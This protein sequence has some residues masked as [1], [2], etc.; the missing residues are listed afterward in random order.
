MIENSLGRSPTPDQLEGVADQTG[1]PA[2]FLV[3]HPAFK[4]YEIVYPRDLDLV[5][6]IYS[7]T[8]LD[9][10]GIGQR[11]YTQD[12]WFTEVPTEWI[13]AEFF[14]KEYREAVFEALTNRFTEGGR[15]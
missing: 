15:W 13:A 7:T 10:E 11:A 12:R 4:S 2:L 5:D 8:V 1:R 14:S 6:P 9:I 3:G